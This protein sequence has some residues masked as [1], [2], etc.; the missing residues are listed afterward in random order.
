MALAG[1]PPHR[2]GRAELPHPALALGLTPILDVC[3]PVPLTYLLSGPASG[4]CGPVAHSPWPV[5]FPPSPPHLSVCSETSSVL[6]NRPTAHVRPSLAHVLGLPNAARLPISSGGQTWALPVLAQGASVHVQGLRPRGAC[7]ILAL[8]IV[9]VWPSVR[10]STSALQ[11][12]LFSA[13]RYPT[14]TSPCQRFA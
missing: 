6:C 9:A 1:H 4:I 14:Y 5:A 13:A 7:S 8:T 12:W 2:S 11:S 10:P 3:A